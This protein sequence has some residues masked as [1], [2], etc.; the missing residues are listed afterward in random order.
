MLTKIR[1]MMYIQSENLNKQKNTRKYQTG[2]TV[3]NSN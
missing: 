3:T 1:R 2:I